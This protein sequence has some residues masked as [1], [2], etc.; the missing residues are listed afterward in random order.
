LHSIEEHRAFYAQLI[1]GS[2]GST[3]DRLRAAFAAVARER[4]LGPGPWSVLAGAK[5][6]PTLS[7]DP[8]LIYQDVVVSLAANRGINNGQPTLHARCLAACAVAAGDTVIH[9]G[10]GTGYY[11]AILASLAGPAGRVVAYEIETDLA[12]RARE[13]LRPWP[14]VEVINASATEGALP[15]ADV[16]YVNAGVTHPL[17]TWLDA[18]NSGG[19]LLFPLTASRNHGVMLLVTRR[20]PEAW[21]VRIVSLAAFIGCVGG[22]DDAEARALDA[23]LPT[24]GARAPKSLHRGTPPDET[25]C[26]VG[27]GWWLSTAELPSAR[28]S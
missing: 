22:R 21:A 24:V 13:N 2:G 28:T 18:L 10:A 16:I 6:I 8:R 14:N 19:R 25:A 23:A 4:F 27:N 11:S 12:G 17:P 1:T 3:D 7:D 26:C 9:V 20:G 15:G 5:F